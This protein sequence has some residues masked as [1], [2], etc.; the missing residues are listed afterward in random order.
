MQCIHKDFLGIHKKPGQ[1]AG[2]VVDEQL[3]PMHELDMKSGDG[4]IWKS[5]GTEWYIYNYSY[6][7]YISIFNM[8][9]F[10]FN[11]I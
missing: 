11:I 10:T 6:I 4:R 3:G 8:Y 1:A 2:C 5:N 9:L 7:Y